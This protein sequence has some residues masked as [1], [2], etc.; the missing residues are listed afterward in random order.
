ME[1]LNQQFVVDFVEGFGVIEVDGI[2]VCIVCKRL[3]NIIKMVEKLG[4]TAAT[5][6]KAVL[7]AADKVVH[8]KVQN[9]F[10]PKDTFKHL[11]DVRSKRDRP[12]VRGKS[13]TILLMEGRDI[14][15]LV[16]GR[17]LSRGQRLGPQQ[18]P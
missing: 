17:N 3:Q 12:V 2:K 4:E 15:I 5:G 16:E 10:L 6:S 8:L 9:K 11:N 14:G 1:L 7:L 13:L 18:M